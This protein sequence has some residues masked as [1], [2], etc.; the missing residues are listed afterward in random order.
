MDKKLGKLDFA[1]QTAEEM[2][3]L[4]R[5]LNPWPSAYVSLDG[6]TLKI[7]SADVV[8]EEAAEATEEAGT[9]IKVE[10]DG[11]YIKTIKG[12]L[13]VKELQ[14]EGKKRMDTKSCLLGYEIKPG[15]KVE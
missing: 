11:F 1:T 14:L 7:W 3:R 8:E 5:G 10:K 2:E 12:C 6:K 13:N 15:M 9:I 4:V